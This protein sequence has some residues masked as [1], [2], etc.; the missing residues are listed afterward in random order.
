MFCSRFIF[1]MVTAPTSICQLP[2]ASLKWRN[3]KVALKLLVH[4]LWPIQDWKYTGETIS[5]LVGMYGSGE[6]GDGRYPLFFPCNYS[7][8][9][10]NFIMKVMN[11][12]IFTMK[13]C[14]D[15]TLHKLQLC[16]LTLPYTSFSSQ[17]LPKCG[18]GSQAV[19]FQKLYTLRWL[20]V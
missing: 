9:K 19:W 14:T 16:R 3:R 6:L 11:V 1:K 8:S 4:Q 20:R 15:V 18:L 12:S 13:M 7:T 2:S 17:S 10:F 5:R